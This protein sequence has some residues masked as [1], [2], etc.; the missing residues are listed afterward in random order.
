MQA[1]L[2]FFHESLSDRV[3]ELIDPIRKDREWLRFA[4]SFI[5]RGG[6]LP[7]DFDDKLD[8]VEVRAF[9][10]VP[11]L[12][13]APA[14][15]ISLRAFA[16]ASTAAPFAAGLTIDGAKASFVRDPASKVKCVFRRLQEPGLSSSAAMTP[17]LSAR[18]K[19][20]STV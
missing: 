5:V 12:D 1:R 6:P 2:Y 15:A 19:Q 7:D 11:K 20:R 8:A 18:R 14:S 10:A 16:R 3:D 4:G 13:Q 17:S 9:E